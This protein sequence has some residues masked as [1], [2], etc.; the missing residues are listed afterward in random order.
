[1]ASGEQNPSG[2]SGGGT[3][4]DDHGNN[5]NSASSTYQ[6]AGNQVVL[7]SRKPLPPGKPGPSRIIILAGGGLPTF[8][9][10][11]V[12]DMRGAK[13]VRITAGAAVK[14]PPVMG[15]PVSIALGTS[16]TVT[17]GSTNGVEIIVAEGQKVTIQCGFAAPPP[18]QNFFQQ[19]EMDGS[20]MTLQSGGTPTSFSKIHMDPDTITLECGWG[21]GPDGP[22]IEMTGGPYGWMEGSIKLSLG[23]NAITINDSG[24]TIKGQMIQL[25]PPEP[26]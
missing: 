6:I 8:D 22:K 21:E 9:D 18:C 12:V 15:E 23:S 19:I 16:P 26:G 2:G 14:G 25:N 7:L 17:A 20:G 1:M 3:G 11:G 5:M 13:G 10:D 24:V 4:M